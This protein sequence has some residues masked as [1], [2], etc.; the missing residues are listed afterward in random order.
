MPF[1]TLQHQTGQLSGRVG[2][3]VDVDPVGANFRLSHWGVA[4]NDEFT[5]LGFTEKKIGANPQQVLFALL[6][7]RNAR[8]YSGVD[9]KVI[10]T[11]ER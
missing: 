3:G 6:C 8:S 9:E 1:G 5:E 2:S 11:S 10:S 4:V 7:E